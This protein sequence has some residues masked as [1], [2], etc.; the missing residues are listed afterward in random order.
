MPRACLILLA[1]LMLTPAA[2]LADV[3]AM[4]QQVCRGKKAGD[5]CSDPLKGVCERGECCRRRYG[6]DPSKLKPNI[7]IDDKNKPSSGPETYQE[8]SECLRCAVGKRRPAAKPS[9]APPDMAAAAPDAA[10][11]LTQAPDMMAPE[12][13]DMPAPDMTPAAPDMAPPPPD[14]PAPDMAAAPPAA[15]KGGMC[16]S[17]P[18]H[19]DAGAWSLFAGALLLATLTARRRA[20]A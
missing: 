19:S 7:G 15:P 18:W 6:S 2:A 1:M 3:I 13:P 12:A 4:D 14:M 8:C 10:P 16:A 9:V 20:Q 17:A 11:D 5:A